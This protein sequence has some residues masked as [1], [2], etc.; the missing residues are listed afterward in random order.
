MFTHTKVALALPNQILRG[1]FLFHFV[2]VYIFDD[3][4]P[5]PIPPQ[6]GDDEQIVKKNKRRRRRATRD[7]QPGVLDTDRQTSVQHERKRKRR[8][9]IT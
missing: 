1:F 3:D 4:P 8:S 2:G 7:A 5:D 6:S 9:M